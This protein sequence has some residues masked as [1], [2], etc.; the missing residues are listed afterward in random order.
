MPLRAE[1]TA[2]KSNFIELKNHIRSA[3]RTLTKAGLQKQ[4]ITTI[5]APAFEILANN[6][7]GHLTDQTLAMFLHHS[8]SASYIIPDATI[9]YLQRIEKG[10]VTAPI[11]TRLSK[12]QTYLLLALSHGHVRLYKGD[13]YRIDRLYP[14][15]VPTSMIHTLHIDEYPNWRETHPIAPASVG[16]GSR[17]YHS[18]YDL[19]QT[20]KQ[21]LHTF[22]RIVDRKIRELTNGQNLPLILGGV[23]YLLPIYRKVSKYPKIL[24]GSVSGNL[25]RSSL[26]YLHKSAIAAL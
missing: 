12:N 4:V 18:Q 23:D 15:E 8:Y 2:S 3:K 26:S 13:A 11:Q 25:D 21:M 16:K 20:D 9:P 1:E 14:N 5:L 24:H 6:N 22:F 17:A 7:L 10:F 19:S